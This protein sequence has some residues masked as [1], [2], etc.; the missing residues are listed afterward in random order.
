MDSLKLSQD[1]G[2]R[3]KFCIYYKKVTFYETCKGKTLVFFG[4]KVL[5]NTVYD[6]DKAKRFV[7]ERNTTPIDHSISYWYQE[8]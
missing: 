7:Y 4:N 8:E 3:R 5:V 1:Q 6:E 2:S